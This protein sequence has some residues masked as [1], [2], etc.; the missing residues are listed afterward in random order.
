MKRMNDDE[1]CVAANTVREALQEAAEH[2]IDAMMVCLVAAGVL[3]IDA[4][5]SLE[6]AARRMQSACDGIVAG[7]RDGHFMMAQRSLNS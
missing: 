6:V 1:I 7:V 2:P 5:E 3:C 4:K